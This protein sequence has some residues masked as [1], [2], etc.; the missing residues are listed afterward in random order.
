M[1]SARGFRFLLSIRAVKRKG[2]N[3]VLQGR[4]SWLDVID[5][6][7]VLVR[8]LEILENLLRKCTFDM[9]RTECKF[10]DDTAEGY[11]GS[12]MLLFLDESLLELIEGYRT[13]IE[14]YKVASKRGQTEFGTSTSL[15]R[16]KSRIPAIQID[17]AA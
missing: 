8:R 9:P 6:A 3:V 12:E 7:G 5:D 1:M 13:Q 4:S 16:K 11:D 15:G 17:K 14:K 2:R 10:V